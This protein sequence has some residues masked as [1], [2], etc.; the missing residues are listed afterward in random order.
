MLGRNF[1]IYNKPKY[2]SAVAKKVN[3]AY[4]L[5]Y[6]RYIPADLLTNYKEYRVTDLVRFFSVVVHDTGGLDLYGRVTNEYTRLHL[7]N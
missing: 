4:Y 1:I 2:V 5:N 6:V 3:R 7:F